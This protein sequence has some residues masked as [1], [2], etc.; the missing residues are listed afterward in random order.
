MELELLKA[1]CKRFEA[2]FQVSRQLFYSQV[3][4]MNSADL[5]HLFTWLH[6]KEFA[7]QCTGTKIAV[8]VAV[9]T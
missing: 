3:E 2:L 8:E 4:P 9:L 7:P 5:Y 6:Q 1:N